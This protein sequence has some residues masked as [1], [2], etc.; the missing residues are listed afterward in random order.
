MNIALAEDS[1]HA[2]GVQ[3]LDL[4]KPR[5]TESSYSDIEA[6]FDLYPESGIEFSTYSIGVGN[7]PGRNTV[8]WEVRNY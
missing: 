3:V 8:I 5:M 1:H 6:L 4:L 7:I 2:Y